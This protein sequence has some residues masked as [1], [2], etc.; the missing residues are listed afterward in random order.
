MIKL[1]VPCAVRRRFASSMGS[2]FLSFD[3]VAY[4]TEHVAR[5]SQVAFRG[6]P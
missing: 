5:N 1:T 2:S 3:V 4:Q 6:C